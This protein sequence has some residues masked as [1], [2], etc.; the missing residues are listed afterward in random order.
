[1][2]TQIGARATSDGG[3]GSSD[4]A[5]AEQLDLINGKRLMISK[6]ELVR[7]IAVWVGLV[8]FGRQVY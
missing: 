1:M 4:E 3:G 2:L 7:T 8:C 5:G 6:K